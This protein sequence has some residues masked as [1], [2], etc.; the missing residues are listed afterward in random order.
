MANVCAVSLGVLL[1]SAFAAAPTVFAADGSA[2]DITITAEGDA[3][4]ALDRNFP[5]TAGGT[6]DVSNVRGSVT[7][8]GGNGDGVKLGGSLGAGSKLAIE[9]DAHRLEMRVESANNNGWLGGKGP[10][11]DTDLI[12]NVPHGVSVKLDVVSANG[13]IDNIDGKSV[14]VDNVSGDVRVSAAAGT[15]EID[16]VSGDVTLQVTR[17]GVNERT[18]LE[19][20]SGNINATGADGRVKLETVSGRVTFEAPSVGELGAESVSGDIHASFAPKKGAHVR[21]ETMSG[22]LSLRLPGD[23]AARIHAETFSG[24]LKTDYGKVVKAEFG[25]GSSLDVDNGDSGTRVDAQ[26]FSGNVELR[27]Q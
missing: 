26:S 6:I 12:L 9:G 4:K 22:N 13:K 2:D 11:N 15:V 1:A 20:V 25:P 5:F 27:K 7:I 18:H 16:S 10:R 23:L 8:T 3:A 17:S 21:A 14:E 24:N 19:T